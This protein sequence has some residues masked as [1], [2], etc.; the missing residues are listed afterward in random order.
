MAAVVDF[1]GTVPRTRDDVRGL[2]PYI[3]QLVGE[4]FLFARES[5]GD[6]LTLHFGQEVELP[7]FRGRRRTEGTHVLTLR[8]SKWWIKSVPRAALVASDDPGPGLPGVPVTLRD[9]E[10]NPPIT[11][12]ERVA[13]V[14]VRPFY[15]VGWPGGIELA[16]RFSDG[17]FLELRPR[18]DP[19]DA[20]HDLADWEL[21]TP[22]KRYIKAGP[23]VQWEYA[24]SDQPPADDAPPV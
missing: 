4:P 23:G 17:S 24:P 19:E 13:W 1:R 8:A 21:F 14:E 22:Y 7:P 6:E 10:L 9:L 2:Q 15:G 12:G 18:Y 5:Y 16:F 11:P 3:R 20:V